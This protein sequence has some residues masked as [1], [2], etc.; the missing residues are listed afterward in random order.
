MCFVLFACE[1]QQQQTQTHSV[2]SVVTERANAGIAAAQARIQRD[3]NGKDVPRLNARIA[4]LQALERCLANTTITIEVC[5]KQFLD[6][7]NAWVAEHEKKAVSF[8]DQLRALYAR[9]EACTEGTNEDVC[10]APVTQEI[11]RVKEEM[12]EHER[13][14]VFLLSKFI[15]LIC[16]KK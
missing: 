16:F 6:D 2:R 8:H 11:R 14:F 3:P 12:R 7:H 13:Y 9:L 15:F 10:S 1:G 4:R 5:H